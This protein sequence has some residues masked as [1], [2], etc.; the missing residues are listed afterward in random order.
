MCSSRSLPRIHPCIPP[1]TDGSHYLPTQPPAFR[2]SDVTI[3]SADRRGF[4]FSVCV[5]L[6]SLSF[7]EVKVMPL[8]CRLNPTASPTV[9]PSDLLLNIYFVSLSRLRLPRLIGSQPTNQPTDTHT[10]THTHTHK[11]TPQTN[12]FTTNQPT[13]TPPHTHTHTHKLELQARLATSCKMPDPARTVLNPLVLSVRISNLINYVCQGH[14]R[15]TVVE[16]TAR[17]LLSSLRWKSLT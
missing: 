3:T 8:V 6:H 14:K 2:C 12:R 16:G 5:P 11:Q 4:H 9:T 15:G 17:C 7:L 13:N 1:H 10:H